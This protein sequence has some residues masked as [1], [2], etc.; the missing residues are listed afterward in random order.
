LKGGVITG[1]D[2]KEMA[3]SSA[4]G[5]TAH[6]H[7]HEHM[8]DQHSHLH[9]S[10]VQAR[11]QTAAVL[12]F[13]LQHNIH[14]TAELREQSELMSGEAQHLLLHAVSAYEEGNAYLADALEAFNAQAK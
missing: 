14:H 12:S 10:S 7:H 5:E 3:C 11:E 4:A 8:H 9:G 1:H 2:L 6:T 13:M